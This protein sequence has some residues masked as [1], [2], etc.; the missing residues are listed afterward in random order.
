MTLK[1]EKIKRKGRPHKKKHKPH[2]SKS[3][4][5]G[6]TPENKERIKSKD[7]RLSHFYRIKNKDTQ[8]TVFK[9]NRA[10]AHFLKNRHTRNIILKSR[11]LGFT[12]LMC[13]DML[14]STLWTRNHDSLLIAQT[15]D[16]AVDIFDNKISLAWEHYPNIFKN[17]YIL[18]SERANKLK[19]GFPLPPDPKKPPPKNGKPLC[20]YSS[21]S[22]KTSGRSGMFR[23]VH[24]S[25]FGKICS[26][27]PE[28]ATEIISG[29]LPTIPMDGGLTI[30]STA[31][32]DFGYFHD[33]FWN[34]YNRPTTQ[35]LNPTDLKAH[36]Y[37]WTWDDKE[38]AKSPLIPTEQMPK[39]FQDYKEKHN[40][41]EIEIS[42]YFLKWESLS[43]NDFLLKQEYPTTPE[44]AFETSSSKLFSLDNISK[45]QKY[46]N[47]NPKVQG[48]W[49]IFHE[50]KPNHN[51][52]IG[53]DPSEGT[54][55][56]ASA[57]VIWDFTPTKP[58]VVATFQNDKT[59]PD[60]FAFELK[61]MGILYSTALI[62]VER[63][64][65]G[66][67]VLTK[68]KDIYPLY[69]IYKE[70]KEDK[71]TN[72]QTE[73]LGWHSNTATKPQI[74]FDYNTAL[75]E[76]VFEIADANILMEMRT[77]EREDINTIRSNKEHTK[78][79]DLLMSAMIGWQGIK[80]A[81]RATE[82]RTYVAGRGQIMYN[83]DDNQIATPQ[84]NDPFSPI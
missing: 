63:N 76:D 77:Y 4:P 65:H 20:I 60:L 10:Q 16:D 28:R 35:K 82:V 11:Q 12:T 22:V 51:Y 30:E 34:A 64:N 40:L 74:I 31:E 73:K 19:F 70:I 7:F 72:T 50:A 39:K 69:Q 2:K 58:K 81:N 47:T 48:S 79:W 13:I 49:K 67:A 21:I 42:Y 56:D 26:K 41:S 54:G 5:Y 32:G 14:D 84:C 57:A 53:A 15:A 23:N 18:D 44:E 59:P 46:V 45:Q 80:H 36:F 29:T 6:L 27:F 52:V 78:H 62:I 43:K 55:R 33:M 1:P 24:I 66:H 3:N 75:N 17:M 83:G 61:N 68:L 8:L 38:I 9:P 71:T 25:E 37:N